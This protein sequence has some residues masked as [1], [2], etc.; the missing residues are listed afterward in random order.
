M[1][2]ILRGRKSTVHIAP[3]HPTVL[4]GKYAAS[5]R[6]LSSNQASRHIDIIKNGALAQIAAGADI[7]NVYTD[8]AATEQATLLPRA[9]EA[10]QEVVEVPLSIDSAD[11]Q[12]LTAALKVYQGKPLVNSVTGE[13]GSLRQV[14]PLVAEHETAVIG[15]C[16][17]ET[18]IPD[19]PERR[20]A[21]AHKIVRRAEELGIPREDVLIDCM[22]KA[23]EADH[24]AALVTLETIRLVKADLGVNMTLDISDISFELPNCEALHRGFLSMVLTMGVNAPIVN[25]AQA[26]QTIVAIDVLL[27]R[28]D[29]AARYIKYYHYHRSGIRGLIDW[30]MVG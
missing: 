4:I 30:E 15:L 18:G 6:H 12:A 14:L 1:E 27:G 24:N 10:L 16:V 25:T 23:I 20:L 9:V 28:N 11:P 7:V 26:R 29:A 22:T 2:T 17:D 19:D 21:I 13:E 5:K 3:D 8:T